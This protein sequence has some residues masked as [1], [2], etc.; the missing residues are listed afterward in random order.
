MLRL[1]GL[2]RVSLSPR[3]CQWR[4]KNRGA[5]QE[6]LPIGCTS[7]AAVFGGKKG[8][9]QRATTTSCYLQKIAGELSNIPA[10]L[11]CESSICICRKSD[12][13]HSIVFFYFLAAYG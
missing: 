7:D 3:C 6:N 12:S 13:K 10:I 4:E 11:S 5:G 8:R 1:Q 9:V 2:T